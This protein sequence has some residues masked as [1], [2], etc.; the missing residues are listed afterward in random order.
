M[1]V[2]ASSSSAHRARTRN[3]AGRRLG[4]CPGGEGCEFKRRGSMR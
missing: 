1:T 2:R 3:R 4:A